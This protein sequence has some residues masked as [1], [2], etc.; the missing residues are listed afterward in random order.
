MLNDWLRYW[1]VLAIDLEHRPFRR[2]VVKN[3]QN[4]HYRVA[5][6]QREQHSPFY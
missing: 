6:G 4:M 3:L 1:D 5:L 2:S